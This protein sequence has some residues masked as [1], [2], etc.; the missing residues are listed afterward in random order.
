MII[1]HVIQYFV[2]HRTHIT[3]VINH[4]YGGSVFIDLFGWPHDANLVLNVLMNT[5]SKRE[6]LPDVLYLQLD[7]TARENKNQYVMGFLA[8]LVEIGVFKEV[9]SLLYL[10]NDLAMH[11]CTASLVHY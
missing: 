3:G 6:V 8:L 11:S 1:T 4:A 10:W 7:N 5:I 2:P 9:S